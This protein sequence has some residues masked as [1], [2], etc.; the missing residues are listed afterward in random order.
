ELDETGVLVTQPVGARIE[1]DP[2]GLVHEVGEARLTVM[3]YRHDAAGQAHRSEAL[4][5][6][7]VRVAEALGEA[8]SPLGDRIAAAERV[9][10]T[11]AERIELL[12]SERSEEH[13]SELQSQ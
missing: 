1:L 13:T 10:P 4:Q 2:P 3:A 12:A 5:L 7:V 11:A 6:L 9:G 8:V